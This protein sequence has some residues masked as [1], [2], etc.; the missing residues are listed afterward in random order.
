M[1]K[2]HRWEDW[3]V[4]VA[5]L[6][7]LLTPIWG[8]RIGSSVPMLLT[9]GAMLFLVG[10]VDLAGPNLYGIEVGQI[11]ASV[12]AIILPWLGNFAGANVPA[13]TAWIAGGIALVSTLLAINPSVKAS[14]EQHAHAS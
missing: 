2:W 10:I 5:G 3:A 6:V 9:S 12:L 13:L 11:L 4:T 8:E 7:M 14:R 1:R